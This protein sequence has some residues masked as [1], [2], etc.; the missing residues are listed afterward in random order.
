MYNGVW[1]AGSV[2]DR[3]RRNH[4]TEGPKRS[5]HVTARS[6]APTPVTSPLSREAAFLYNNLLLVALC[7]TVLW[8][9]IFPIL[10]DIFLNQPR[11]IGRPYFDLNYY[12]VSKDG[13]YAGAAAY[14]G[15]QFAVA[16]ARGARL[17]P[18][19]YLFKAEERP[20]GRPISGT[21]QR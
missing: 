4:V 6:C 10:T 9:V 19:V 8:G 20:R 21:M 15:S 13:R 17:E 12:A 5:R 14:A 3:R 18:V 2:S 11:T 16:D 7:L 1:R